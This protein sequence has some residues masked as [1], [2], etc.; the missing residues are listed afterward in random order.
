[1][2]PGDPVMMIGNP[3]G[4]D[5]LSCSTGVVRDSYWTDPAMRLPLVGV[6][7]DIRTAPGNSGS[8]IVTLDGHVA[9]M[10]TDAMDSGAGIASWHIGAIVRRIV[11]AEPAD[12]NGKNVRKLWLTD[13]Y[14]LA[15]N[16]PANAWWLH[17]D[18]QW[19]DQW[20][21]VDGFLVRWVRW[22][23]QWRALGR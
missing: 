8:P 4:I 17:G 5:P 11:R 7:T 19:D 13:D 2:A 9:S 14:G 22:R 1:M 20:V 21:D 3:L 18:D 10:H 12:M 23:R 15:P 6:M 16:T